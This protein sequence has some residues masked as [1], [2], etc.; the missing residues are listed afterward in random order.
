MLVY[1]RG[2]S[3]IDSVPLADVRS[4][5]LAALDMQDFNATTSSYDS[6]IASGD[7][8]LVPN[9]DFKLAMSDD[10]NTPEA[11]AV[12]F[13]VVRAINKQLDSGLDCAQEVAAFNQICFVLGIAY[14]DPAEFLG[15]AI[16]DQQ[17]IVAGELSAT[18]VQALLEERSVAKIDK[19]WA[20]A[21]EIRDQLVAIGIS[22]EDKPGGTF[23]WSVKR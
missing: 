5:F 21:D 12:L 4:G 14:Q 9:V 18:E 6:A 10:F 17:A 8:R 23:S 16:S 2:I 3:T 11:L 22:I 20:R 7:I 19:N 1:F 13:D 15:I